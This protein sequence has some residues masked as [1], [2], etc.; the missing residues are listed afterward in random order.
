MVKVV[1][2]WWKSRD[3]EI[4][5]VNG[6]YI[7]LS[8]W[9]GESFLDCWEVTELVDGLGFDILKDGIIARPVYNDEL[10]SDDYT[11]PINYELEG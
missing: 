10:E 7:A 9:N 11:E 3:I 5:E 1:G 2:T 6:R 8:G 4:V